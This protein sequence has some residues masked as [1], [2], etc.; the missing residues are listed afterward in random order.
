MALTTFPLKRFDTFLRYASFTEMFEC[1]ADG[2]ILKLKPTAVP[3]R[4]KRQK[5][6]MSKRIS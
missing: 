6:I 2:K 5:A 3:A 4:N 1:E